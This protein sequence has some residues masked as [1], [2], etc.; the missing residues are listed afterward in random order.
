MQK[1]IKKASCALLIF[2]LLSHALTVCGQSFNK[3]EWTILSEDDQIGTA[4]DT[5]FL[6]KPCFKLDSKNSAIAW[7][8]GAELEN[9][10]I[11]L[12]IAGAV[13]SGIGFHVADEQNYQFIYFRPGYGRTVE[14]IQYIP[15][16][17]GALSWVFYGAY[18]D[19]A[20]IQSLQWFHETIV[21]RGNNLKVYTNHNKKPD[22]DIMLLKT[23][24]D[25]GG[26]LLRTLFGGSYF[27]NIAIRELP[28]YLTHWEISEQLPPNAAYDYSQVKKMG[29]WMAIGEAG[30][31]YVNLCRYFENPQGDVFAR[32]N[33]HAD[34]DGLAA[35]AFDFTGKMH[36]W[37]NGVEIFH[38]D[39]YKLDRVEDGTYNVLLNLKKGDNELVLLTEGDGFV[40]NKG[41]K[42]MGRLQHQNW[43]FIASLMMKR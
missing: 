24:S 37:L 42:T 25:K 29:K 10:S 9:F 17:N 27:A 38:Y 16:Y 1:T 40:F 23:A 43:G 20:D 3:G 8:K 5:V 34:L 12:D 4:I 39:K 7:K 2:G 26:I 21:V 28:H 14:A 11:D 32:H 18:Q 19:T 30:D 13:M 41:F 15:I 6:G 22:M 33:I 31:Q 35:F 36:I